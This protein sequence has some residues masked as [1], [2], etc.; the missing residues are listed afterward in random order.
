VSLLE[1]FMEEQLRHF[2]DSLVG[3]VGGVSKP[4]YWGIILGLGSIYVVE[5]FTRARP[6]GIVRKLIQYIGNLEIRKS[7]PQKEEYKA[8]KVEA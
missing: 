2:A 4:V 6:N 3:V 8:K 1:A 7:E 5:I